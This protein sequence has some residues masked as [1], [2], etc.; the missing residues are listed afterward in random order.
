MDVPSP[1][2]TVA[3]LRTLSHYEAN[4][5]DFWEGTK[6]HDVSQNYDALLES[7]DGAPPFTILDFGCGPGRD[8][9]YFRSLGHEAVGLDGCSAFCAMARRHSGCD[10]YEQDF[11][12]LSLP[13]DRF[14]G[15]FANASL[16]HVPSRELPRVLR[17]LWAAMKRRGVLFASNPVGHDEE[18]WRGDRYGCY[19]D[20]ERWRAIVTA[21]GFEEIAHYYRP[22]GKPREE[23]PW[24]ATVWRKVGLAKLLRGPASAPDAPERQRLS[25]EAVQK[26]P[27]T[28]SPPPCSKYIGI[29]TAITVGLSEAS[30]SPLA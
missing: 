3:S 16:F 9:S 12:A 29:G 11:L 17:E 24:L 23:Q 20:L 22:K 25:R 13:D 8:L 30:A 1:K 14:H 15:V 5:A 6:H 27:A 28:S 10:V 4:A 2:Q 26:I 7:L 18:G 19:W 21:S